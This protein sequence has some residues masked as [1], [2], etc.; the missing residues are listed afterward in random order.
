MYEKLMVRKTEFTHMEYEDIE[1]M[2]P[3]ERRRA[4]KLIAQINKKQPYKSPG[5][6]LYGYI[7]PSAIANAGKFLSECVEYAYENNLI[8]EKTPHSFV[9]WA[10]TQAMLSITQE[11]KEKRR[12]Y[13]LELSQD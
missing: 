13:A 2:T 4:Q 11:I 5:I 7:K 3:E 1:K 8:D 10:V 9:T 6:R 12:I